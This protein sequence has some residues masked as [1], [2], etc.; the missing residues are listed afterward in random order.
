[1]PRNFRILGQYGAEEYISYTNQGLLPQ[2][3]VS[4][5]GED[6]GF[7]LPVFDIR[8]SAAKKTNY[9]KVSQNELAI[10][11]F[12]L[13]FFNPQLQIRS[14]ALMCLEMMDFDGKDDI[15]QKVSQNGTLYDKLVQYMQLSLVLAQK[16]APQYVE[17][18]A[19]DLQALGVPAMPKAAGR[20][21]PNLS[22]SD[23]VEGV[24]R[25]EHGI[26]ENARER[27]QNAG[28]PEGGR[29]VKEERE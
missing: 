18:I 3:Q 22:Q 25:K 7:R 2:H 26:V 19:T 12:Q 10:Q 20:V 4:A 27:A 29:V 14:Q 17:Q 23:N 9:T 11:F 21:D 13:G 8:I 1:M 28:Q 5:F 16:A 6:M 15:M 24:Q